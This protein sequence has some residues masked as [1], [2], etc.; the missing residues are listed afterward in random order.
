MLTKFIQPGVAKSLTRSGRAL[1][2][3]K[4]PPSCEPC[5]RSDRTNDRARNRAA[6]GGKCETAEQNYTNARNRKPVVAPVITETKVVEEPKVFNVVEQMPEFPGG[7]GALFS[8][9]QNNIQYPSMERDNDIQGKV[10]VGFVVME[11]GAIADVSIKRAVSPGLD[12]EAARVVR[13]LP[14]FKPGKQQ[15]KAVR[16]NYVLPIVFKLAQ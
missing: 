13:L 10:I 16:V 2:E 14:K 11:D 8:F 1:L 3:S 9:I 15:G 12:K 6:N 5:S 7:D 4:L